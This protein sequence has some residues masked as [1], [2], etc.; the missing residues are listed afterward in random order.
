MARRGFISSPSLLPLEDKANEDGNVSEAG[1]FTPLERLSGACIPLVLHA[2]PEKQR[3]TCVKILGCQA[4]A[5]VW[6][7]SDEARGLR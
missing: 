2:L 3:P 7:G 1:M 6:G 4:N 5:S